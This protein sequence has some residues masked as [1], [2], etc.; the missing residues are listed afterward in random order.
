MFPATAGGPVLDPGDGVA[1]LLDLVC[2]RVADTF[3]TERASLRADL[4]G[5][6]AGPAMGRFVAAAEDLV[7][8]GRARQAAYVER[9]VLRSGGFSAGDQEADE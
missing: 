7:A 9:G 3:A 1:P 8:R 2:G 4:L 5:S 6:G